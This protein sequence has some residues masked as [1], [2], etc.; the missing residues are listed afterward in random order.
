MRS[1]PSGVSSIRAAAGG[2]VDQP[3]GPLDILLH[4][5][6]QIGAAGNQLGAGIGG[7]QADRIGDV[8]GAGI[9]EVVHGSAHCACWMAA[10]MFG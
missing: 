7:E 6:D 8:G 2:N 5:V 9:L 4:Q 1:P 10:T 3:G